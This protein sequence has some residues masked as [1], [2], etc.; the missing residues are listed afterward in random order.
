MTT[1]ST[2]GVQT[3]TSY[4]IRVAA[5]SVDASSTSA[6]GSAA[7]EGAAGAKPTAMAGSAL[8]AVGVLGAALLL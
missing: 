5:A 2:T 4:G 8:A 6:S 1:G 7:S 3:S